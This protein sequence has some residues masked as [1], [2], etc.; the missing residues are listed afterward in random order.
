MIDGDRMFY[1]KTKQFLRLLIIKI[2][3]SYFINIWLKVSY[4]MF[5]NS[6][7]HNDYN[8]IAFT[9]AFV[10]WLTSAISDQTE[11]KSNQKKKNGGEG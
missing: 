1:C 9:E 8:E 10:F 6:F 2:L 3:Q 5:L 4:S 7:I 11:T